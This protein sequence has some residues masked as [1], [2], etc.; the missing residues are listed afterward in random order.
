MPS[1]IRARVDELRAEHRLHILRARVSELSA[2]VSGLLHLKLKTMTEE[3]QITVDRL[4]NCTGGSALKLGK[5]PELLTSLQQ[6]GLI[7][8]DSFGLGVKTGP[9]GELLNSQ[10]NI[11]AGCFVIGP[12]RRASDWESTA[13]REIREQAQKIVHEI[14]KT[15]LGGSF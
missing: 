9:C 3:R 11:V 12:L 4:F 13:M 5:L 2:D 14:K 10:E 15:N 8:L 6:Q 7:A 1:L